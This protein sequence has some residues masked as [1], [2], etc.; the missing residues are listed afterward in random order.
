[1]ID[2]PF[3]KGMPVL[4]VRAGRPCMNDPVYSIP[5]LKEGLQP[6]GYIANIF[7][8]EKELLVQYY[9]DPERMIYTFE[10]LDGQWTDLFGG[11]YIIIPHESIDELKQKIKEINDLLG[12]IDYS[13]QDWPMSG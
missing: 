9:D 12:P 3:P 11:T 7:W 8:D 13:W 4:R 6:N 5:R 2:N 1:M 10:E